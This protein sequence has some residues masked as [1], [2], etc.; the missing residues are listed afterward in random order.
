MDCLVNAFGVGINIPGY[1]G[2]LS[3]RHLLS[4][5]FTRKRNNVRSRGRGL[6]ASAAILGRGRR[7]RAPEMT[8]G[9]NH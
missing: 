3:P 8:F 7:G 6:P 5:V 1:L 4:L 9:T 2:P